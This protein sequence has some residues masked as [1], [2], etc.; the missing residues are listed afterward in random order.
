M[1]FGLGL[2]DGIAD[3]PGL[4]LARTCPRALAAARA[5]FVLWEITARSFSASAANK[6][7]MKG[8]ASAPSSATRNGT[9]C[10]WPKPG[11][12]S[13]PLAFAG[14]FAP[15]RIFPP[16]DLGQ[17]GELLMNKVLMKC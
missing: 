12:R 16:G 1:G 9:R 13:C 8:S 4:I 2:L 14:L 10:V 7:N 6:C 3:G 11:E 5:A 15:I 17:H